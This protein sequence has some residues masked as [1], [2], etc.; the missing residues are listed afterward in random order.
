MIQFSKITF[1]IILFFNSFGCEQSTVKN[2]ET[3]ETQSGPEIFNY[4]DKSSLNKYIS[5][6]LDS[7][8]PNLFTQQTTPKTFKDVR[9]SWITLH[10]DLSGFLKAHHFNW[11]TSDSIISI[12]HKIYFQ[13]DGEI[14]YHFFRIFNAGI[15]EDKQVEFAN[16]LFKFDSSYQINLKRDSLFAQC[17]KAKYPT[18]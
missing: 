12:L 18:Y 8:Y 15:T 5:L 7:V 14:K 9:D 1:I 13:K 11:N 6:E 10:N 3:T 16:L 17:G 4:S 2:S